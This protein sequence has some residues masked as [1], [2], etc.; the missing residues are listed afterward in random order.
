MEDRT[1]FETATTQRGFPASP[2]MKRGFETVVTNVFDDGLDVE[3]EHKLIEGSLVVNEALT[4]GALQR[5]ANI[6][7]DMARRSFRLF[8]IAKV[9]YE[10]YIRDTESIVGAIRE[11]ATA[12]LE[13]EKAAKIRTKQITES[14]V[15]ATAAQIYP[16]E[17]NEIN[18]RRERARGMLAYIEN[19]SALAK[20]RCYTVSH[21]LAPSGK[22]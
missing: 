6:A 22:L 14:D 1:V 19:L 15:V 12:R 9:E 11:A 7:E 2:E 21:M 5:A 17:W 16:D 8:V 3:D 4:P 20:S 13:K 10:A 18:N